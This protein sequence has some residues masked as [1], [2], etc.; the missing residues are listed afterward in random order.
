MVSIVVINYLVMYK[1]GWLVSKKVIDSKVPIQTYP[2]WYPNK[3]DEMIATHICGKERRQ[4]GFI[5]SWVVP[6]EICTDK[7]N[8]RI[9]LIIRIF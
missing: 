5:F 4:E 1:Y 9:R 7:S 3:K 2:I 6:L 8:S